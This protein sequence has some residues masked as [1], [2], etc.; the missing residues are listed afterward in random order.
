MA[1]EGEERREDERRTWRAEGKGSEDECGWHNS[2][3]KT[4]KE[5]VG[6][7]C[8]EDERLLCFAR[9]VFVELCP[10]SQ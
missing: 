9:V 5:K 10:S 2:S 1:A 7:F 8:H 3:S 4:A 6:R